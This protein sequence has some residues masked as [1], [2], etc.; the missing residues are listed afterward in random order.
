MN[1]PALRSYRVSL[2]A[3]GVYAV[4]VTAESREAACAV[5]ERLWRKDH[6]AFTWCDGGIEHIEVLDEYEDGGAA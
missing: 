2:V 1:I 5:A 3:Y 6:S 4:W